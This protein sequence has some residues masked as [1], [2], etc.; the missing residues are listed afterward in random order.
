MTPMKP[1]K[2]MTIRLSADQADALETLANVEQRAVSDV[3]RAAIE[4]HIETK[5]RDPHFQEGL[6]ERINRARRLLRG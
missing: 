2:A 6:Q 5:R 4:E 1:A 3:I